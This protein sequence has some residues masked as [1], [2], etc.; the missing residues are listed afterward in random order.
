[1]NPVH[2]RSTYLANLER[3][4]QALKDGCS[5]NKVSLVPMTITQPYAEALAQFLALRM[6]QA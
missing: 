2:L 6:R 3:Y 5:R 4:R 1:M